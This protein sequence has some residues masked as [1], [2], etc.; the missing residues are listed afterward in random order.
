MTACPS[1]LSHISGVIVPFR[2]TGR[3][4]AAHFIFM[5]HIGVNCVASD[6]L[7][8]VCSTTFPLSGLPYASLVLIRPP[9][10]SF[11]SSL[12]TVGVGHITPRSLE[13][14]LS[15]LCL[16]LAVALLIIAFCS[17]SPLG[18]GSWLVLGYSLLQQV[19]CAVVFR[20]LLFATCL[21]VCPGSAYFARSGLTSSSS[22]DL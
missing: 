9:R 16:P 10:L 21:P 14:D 4:C 8:G 17:H 11:G 12:W 6:P 2:A 15:L 19:P 5:F 1:M 3:P 13:V 18:P 7:S 22:V 20:R